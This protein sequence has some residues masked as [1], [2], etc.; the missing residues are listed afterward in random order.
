MIGIYSVNKT[1]E[2]HN[3]HR[4]NRHFK[5][6]NHENWIKAYLNNIQIEPK[7]AVV[8]W[9][10]EMSPNYVTQ[11]SQF[12]DVRGITYKKIR[13]MTGSEQIVRVTKKL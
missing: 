8:M 4:F 12:T 1:D 6:T 11:V 7:K 2:L 3:K 5:E 10:K 13:F 9:N